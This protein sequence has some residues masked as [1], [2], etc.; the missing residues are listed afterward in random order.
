MRSIFGK[1]CKASVAAAAADGAPSIFGKLC[2]ASDS[3]ADAEKSLDFRL[4]AGV[5]QEGVWGLDG[6]SEFE[7]GGIGG[8]S[9]TVLSL[10]PR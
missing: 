6:D 3:A 8:G 2:D 5:R 4:A 9:V 10:D 1:L 7:G